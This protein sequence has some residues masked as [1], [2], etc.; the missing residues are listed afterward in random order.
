MSGKLNSQ[1]IEAGGMIANHLFI[2]GG[3]PQLT[4]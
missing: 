1:A 3:A 2:A 4:T